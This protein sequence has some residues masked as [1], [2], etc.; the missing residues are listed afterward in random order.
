MTKVYDDFLIDVRIGKLFNS[1]WPLTR[2]NL[3][4]DWVPRQADYAKVS[5]SP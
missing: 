1:N 5:S 3:P 4:Q 2:A